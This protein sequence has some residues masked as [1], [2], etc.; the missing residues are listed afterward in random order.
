MPWTMNC[1]LNVTENNSEKSGAVG[2]IMSCI[3]CVFRTTFL[4]SH[5]DPT[6]SPPKKHVQ[7]IYLCSPVTTHIYGILPGFQ[8]LFFFF[9]CKNYIWKGIGVGRT[10]YF[11]TPR[12]ICV[13]REH[14]CVSQQELNSCN[15]CF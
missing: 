10:S 1:L 12:V 7:N 8:H 6:P 13:P 4:P 15:K 2:E 11:S 9:L 14:A 5:Y 3:K